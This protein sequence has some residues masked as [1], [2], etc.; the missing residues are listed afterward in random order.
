MDV[1]PETKEVYKK[2]E[3]KKNIRIHFPELGINLTNEAIY[4]E[5]MSLKESI[6]DGNSFEFV[7][8]ISSM[9]SVQIYGMKEEIKGKSIKAYIKTDDTEEIL[10][11]SGIVDSAKQEADKNYKKITAYDN[12][13]EIGKKDIAKWYNSLTFPISLKDFRD[14]LFL[15]LKIIQEETELA[16]DNFKIK[17]EYE[18]K[19]LKAIEVIKALCQ[20]N[21]VFGI[22]SRKEKFKYLKL[23]T[24]ER[25]EVYPSE[26]LYPNPKL[27]PAAKE[28]VLVDREEIAHYKI[29]SYE[30]YQ[31]RP[32][33]KITIRESEEDIGVVYGEGD[34]N[35]IIQGNIF[36][37]GADAEQLQNIARAIYGAVKDTYYY[38]F[39]GV[40]VGLP[41]LECGSMISY[42]TQQGIKSFCVFGRELRG[43]QALEDTYTADGEEFQSEFITDLKLKLDTIQK[44]IKEEV[45]KEIAD[46]TY[47]KE[48]I[49]EMANNQLK[50]LSVETLPENPDTNTIYLIQGE[51]S[52]N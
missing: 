33:D 16:N 46:S 13:Y 1:T 17:K 9:F 15:H 36:A 28:G 6:F 26:I 40:G 25:T 43:I 8:C 22:M 20:I 49:D 42:Q 47:T 45:K 44:N 51:V 19:S 52:V 27:F 31:V 11:F 48:Q 24:R 12:L 29:V 35:Y 10:L 39:Q 23:D 41:Y 14:K 50:V 5:S 38:P 30:E 4:K 18:P 32:V 34:N 37:Y 2:D 21:G 7:G 3:S